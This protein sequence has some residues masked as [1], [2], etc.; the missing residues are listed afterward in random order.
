MGRKIKK[1]YVDEE[2]LDTIFVLEREWKSIESIVE[3]SI[4]PTTTAVYK[5][6]FAQ[7]KYLFL[8]R[9]ARHRKISAIR[10]D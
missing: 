6:K 4:E 1:R 7:A 10:Y 8:L 5:E 3:K 9:E 2:L